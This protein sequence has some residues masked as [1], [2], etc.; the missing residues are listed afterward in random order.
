M[1][2]DWNKAIEEILAERLSCPRCD[3]FTDHMVAGY[4][5]EPWGSDYAPRCQFCNRKEDCDARKLVFLCSGCA[6]E[7]GLRS[8]RVDQGQ[9]MTMLLNDCRRD[10]EECL[11]YLLEYW[12]DDL[13]VPAEDADQRLEEYAPDV[14]A[15]EDEARRRLEEEYLTYHRW[16]REH[17]A[18]V[19][20]PG[21]RS[22]Y[23]EE[24]TGLGYS[25][26]L[27]D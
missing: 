16:F 26:L 21:W 12:Q 13:D 25:T 9:L 20:D 19:P 3:S 4:T 1:Q 11:D 15:E 27:G 7:L 5:R 10:L 17:D 24:I 22:E 6:Q 18:R 14:F 2:I 23:V 8:R